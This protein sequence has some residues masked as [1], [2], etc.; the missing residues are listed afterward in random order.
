MINI[1]KTSSLSC[2]VLAFSLG[3][4][5]AIK[6]FEKTGAIGDKTPKVESG[7]APKVILSCTLKADSD[8]KYYVYKTAKNQLFL[9]STADPTAKPISFALLGNQLSYLDIVKDD[10]IGSIDVAAV[11]GQTSD[12]TGWVAMVSNS[13]AKTLE[14]VR[15]EENSAQVSTGAIPTSALIQN[16]KVLFSSVNCQDGKLAD[17]GSKN[18]KT[19]VQEIKEQVAELVDQPVPSKEAVESIRQL[20]DKK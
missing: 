1:K 14:V 2:V 5:G 4:C 16:S 3:A 20:V 7:E 15:Y 8:D 18:G 17:T 19:I 12:K 11:R 9:A 13:S 6:K 10:F